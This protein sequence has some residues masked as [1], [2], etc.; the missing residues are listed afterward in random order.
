MPTYG[1]VASLTRPPFINLCACA[2]IA[3]LSALGSSHS[4]HRA[5]T[6]LKPRQCLTISRRIGGLTTAGEPQSEVAC[7]S[8]LAIGLLDALA[9]AVVRSDLSHTA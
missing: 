8:A 6:P 4:K 3:P 7:L 1:Y 5:P 9:F 2:D